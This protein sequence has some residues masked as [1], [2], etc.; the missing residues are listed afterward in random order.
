[1]KQ[2]LTIE[3]L[4]KYFQDYINTWEHMLAFDMY[5]SDSDKQIKE[6]WENMLINKIDTFKFLITMGIDNNFEDKKGV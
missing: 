6:N 5:W 3:N 4:K 1:M 2:E